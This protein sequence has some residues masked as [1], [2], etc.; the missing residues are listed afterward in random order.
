MPKHKPKT[1]P[2]AK[3][4]SPSPAPEPVFLPPLRPHP[5]LLALLTTL[6]ALWIAA[7]LAL[8]FGM[9]RPYRKSHPAPAPITH[10]TTRPPEVRGVA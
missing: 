3:T 4:A 7:I 1:L 5:K 10:P 2:H 9:V 8:Y 6:L